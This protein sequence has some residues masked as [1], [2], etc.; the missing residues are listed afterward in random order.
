MTD[1]NVA[2]DAGAPPAPASAPASN[3]VVINPNPT[4]A[5]APVGSQAPPK[6]EQATS[7]RDAI[8]KAFNRSR[9]PN[10]PKPKAADAK[11]GHNQPPE[12]TK[13]E[14]QIGYFVGH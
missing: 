9:D 5:P 8:Q 1:T 6:G 2:P 13:R 3:E 10:A 14:T 4:A 12:E 11:M 7:R